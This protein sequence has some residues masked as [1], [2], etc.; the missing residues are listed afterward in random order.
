[1][2]RYQRAEDYRYNDEERWLRS[3]R[4]YRGLYGS[5]VQFTEAEKSR[6]FIKVTKTKTLAAYGQM[7]DVLFAGH[8]FPISVEPTVLP[9]GVVSDVSFDPKKPEQLK[10]ETSLSSPYGFQGDGKE[11]PAGATEKTLQEMLGPVEEKL[12]EIEGLEEG[13]GKTP[14]S[15]TFSPC[16]DCCQEHGKE[17]HGPTSRVRC[18]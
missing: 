9:E 10:G 17:N 7:V 16:H 3:Y 18:K 15:V 4:N 1:M 5:D 8:K 11:L 14:T 6:V 12:G 2:E 13:V